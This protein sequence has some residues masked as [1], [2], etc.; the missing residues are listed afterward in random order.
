MMLKQIGLVASRPLNEIGMLVERKSRVICS[1]MSLSMNR[2]VRDVAFWKISINVNW[3]DSEVEGK[4]VGGVYMCSAC[5]DA[6]AFAALESTE[7]NEFLLEWICSVL[8]SAF[9]CFQISQ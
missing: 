5:L 7:Q 1:L 9:H 6:T 4:I 8:E 2:K 3:S